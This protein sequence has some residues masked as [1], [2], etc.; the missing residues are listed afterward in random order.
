MEGAEKSA[1]LR[2]PFHFCY[3]YSDLL[4]PEQ[5]K[6][7]RLARI[8]GIAI[9]SRAL[10]RLYLGELQETSSSELGWDGDHNAG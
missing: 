10:A 2:Q 7:G 8:K 6:K 5:I 9:T 1:P 4:G 3:L